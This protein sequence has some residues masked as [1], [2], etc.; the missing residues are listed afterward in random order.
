M[1]QDP[2][3]QPQRT[4]DGAPPARWM[5]GV[6]AAYALG[7]WAGRSLAVAGIALAWPPNAVLLAALLAARTRLWPLLLAAGAAAHLLTHPGVPLPQQALQYLHNC[8]LALLAAGGVRWLNGVQPPLDRFRCMALYLGVGALAA[9]AAAALLA[10]WL[11]VPT[12]GEALRVLWWR[13]FL[14]NA[15]GFA[16]LVPAAFG[17]REWPRV[18]RGPPARVAEAAVLGLGLVGAG[19]SAAAELFGGP[20]VHAERTTLPL[21]FLVWAAVRFGRVGA[22]TALLLLTVTLM[23]AA[24]QAGA[25]SG[26]PLPVQAF[27]V[28]VSLPVLLLAA[29][30]E[31]RNAAAARERLA[32]ERVSLALEASHTGTWEWAVHSGRVV[33]SQTNYRIFGLPEGEPAGARQFWAR[34]HPADRRRVRMEAAVALREG[35]FTTELRVLHPDGRVRWVRTSG[36]AVAGGDGRAEHLVGVN[37]DITE[38][39]EAELALRA[40][41]TRTRAILRALPDLMFLQDREGRYLDYYARDVADLLVP[42][43]QF[44]GKRLDE[45][46]PPELSAQLRPVLQATFRTGGP[47]V[48]EY[49]LPMNGRTRHYEA[50]L[51]RCGTDAVLSIVRDVTEERRSQAA[52][53]E[54]EEQ[55]RALTARLLTAQEE[56]RS[57]VAREI[58]DDAGQQLAALAFE[59]SALQRRLEAA[60]PEETD[61]LATLERSI[62]ALAAGIRGISHRLHPSVLE[63]AGL[64]AALRSHCA[65]AAEGMGIAI[66]LEVGPRMERVPHDTALAAYRIVQE[67][68]RNVRHAGAAN[69]WVKVSRVRREL[70]VRVRDDGRG[71]RDGPPAPG[72]LGLVSMRERA[73]LVGGTLWVTSPSRGGT[74]I[75]AR[76]PVRTFPLPAPP[77]GHPAPARGD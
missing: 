76:L 8:V 31:D 9:P 47:E 41:E 38:H 24:H 59:V 18:W 75:E 49:A 14:S 46:L 63:F 64:A 7:V 1:I 69:A 22:A 67:A 54:R 19:L 58:H 17:V 77:P 73:R 27:L 62:E 6:A 74:S 13:D 53:A 56:E 34:V 42:P 5:L 12:S 23:G 40:S 45:V 32:D 55:L 3:R 48:T 2:A 30:V 43:E 52:L 57:R 68:L 72:G 50:R 37:V 10:A 15:L 70:R 39:K 61:A 60:H 20:A 71:M 65:E 16:V 66:H 11:R 44:L 26:E 51:V 28:A 25:A 33:C 29:L 4:H 35:G 21:P 36:R